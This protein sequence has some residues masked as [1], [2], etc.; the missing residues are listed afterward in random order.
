M[1]QPGHLH[2]QP[3]V[4]RQRTQSPALPDPQGGPAC[5]NHRGALS[6]IRGRLVY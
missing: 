4:G 5:R 3:G 1:C 2:Q 6:E